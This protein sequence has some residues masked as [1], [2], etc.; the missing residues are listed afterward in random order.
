MSH[1][2][3]IGVPAFCPRH[4]QREENA[5]M[6][7]AHGHQTIDA[8]DKACGLLLAVVK[9]HICKATARRKL[10]KNISLVIHYLTL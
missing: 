7:E 6:Q 5:E 3:Y 8:T 10:E 4:F 2:D 9:D 1:S